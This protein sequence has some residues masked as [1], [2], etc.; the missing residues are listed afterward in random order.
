MRQTRRFFAYTAALPLFATFLWM[1]IPGC[2]GE[3]TLVAEGDPV[4][5]RKQ[6]EEALNKI[7]NP[8]GVPAQAAK[9][10][11][12][13]KSRSAPPRKVPWT[14]CTFHDRSASFLERQSS[15][16][17]V[18]RSMIDRWGRTSP[19]ELE[20]VGFQSFLDCFVRFAFFKHVFLR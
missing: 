11:G 15:S 13:G 5:R 8:T 18:H 7:S 9:A 12:K 16:A 17:F 10:K 20:R 14:K 6:K 2:S 3:N 4:A 19:T 1:A